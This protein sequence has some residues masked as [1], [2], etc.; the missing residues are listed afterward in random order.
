MKGDART[1]KAHAHG[2]SFVSYTFPYQI[3]NA[4]THAQELGFLLLF[5]I[6]CRDAILNLTQCFKG[7]YL[8]GYVSGTTS[9]PVMKIIS[10]VTLF[11][12]YLAACAVHAPVSAPFPHRTL[13]TAHAQR[14]METSSKLFL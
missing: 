2:L 11:L 7:V 14:K 9:G 5:F 10:W 13:T 3:P 8:E 1:Q 12:S 4:G 6:C